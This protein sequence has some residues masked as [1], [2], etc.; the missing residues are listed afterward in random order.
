MAIL[1]LL[2]CMYLVQIVTNYFFKKKQT[3]SKSAKYNH[4]CTKKI[5]LLPSRRFPMTFLNEFQ[6]FFVKNE[7]K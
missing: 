3:I 1:P 6:N 2:Q 5:N 4:E 7:K